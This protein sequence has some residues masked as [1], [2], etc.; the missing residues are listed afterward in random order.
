VL[1]TCKG[2]LLEDDVVHSV[3]VLVVCAAAGNAVIAAINK[4]ADV[5]AVRRR[6]FEI[7]LAF[8]NILCTG[9]CTIL[10][11]ER[12]LVQAYYLKNCESTR[13][14][15]HQC[16]LRLRQWQPSPSKLAFAPLCRVDDRLDL[17]GCVSRVF[18][19]RG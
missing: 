18:M 4:Y 14:G 13:T 5:Q 11:D 19:L 17:R 8:M 9:V 15:T 2:W 6:S 16:R 3:N 1:I 12:W 7:G 10:A